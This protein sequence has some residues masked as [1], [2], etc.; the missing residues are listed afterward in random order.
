MLIER[1][2]PLPDLLPRV[3]VVA[4]AVCDD[5]RIV[6]A[7]HPNQPLGHDG[8]EDPGMPCPTCSSTAKRRIAPRQA[9]A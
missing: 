9:R 3:A 2:K 4:C 8:C 5:S 6:C 1:V 7:Y